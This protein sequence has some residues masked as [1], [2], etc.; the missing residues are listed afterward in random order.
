MMPGGPTRIEAKSVLR[1]TA[2]AR[3][4][5]AHADLADRAGDSAR[6]NLLAAIEVAT[7]MVL[8]GYWPFRDEIDSRPLFHHF[9]ARGHEC[10]LPVIIGASA[11]V[12]VRPLIFR[13]WRPEMKLAKGRLGEPVPAP[14]A[15]YGTGELIP[16]ILLVPLL[17]FDLHGYRIGYG[18]GH[19][20]ATIASLRAAKP[21]L[22]V[23]LAYSAQEIDIVPR[24][25]HDQRLDWI[26]TEHGVHQI[27]KDG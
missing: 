17:A 3:R 24:E 2:R 4:A 19:F 10:G 20:D 11:G 15:D 5:T 18:G 22:A 26:V 23:G 25:P 7:G 1:A 12:K 16:D 13:P 21:I 14:D 8:G 27:E 9:H 6:D